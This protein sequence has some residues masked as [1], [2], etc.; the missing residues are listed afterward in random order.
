MS[1]RLRVRRR[2]RLIPLVLAAGLFL[3]FAVA[4]AGA[5]VYSGATTQ[6]RPI[7]LLAS[8]SGQLKHVRLSLVA[9]CRRGGVTFTQ[10]SV[11]TFR[12]VVRR[13]FLI[14]SAF[15]GRQGAFRYRT[16]IVLRGHRSST[17]AWAG[18]FMF[19]VLIWRHNRAYDRCAATGVRW[20]AR[21]PWARLMMTSDPGDYIGQG[22]SYSYVTPPDPILATRPT[23]HNEVG[24]QIGGWMLA[25]AAPGARRLTPGTYPGAQRA[26][27]KGSHPGLEVTGQ[28]RGCNLLTG[29]FTVTALDYTRTGEIKDL[30][31]SF[32]QHCEGEPAALRGTLSYHR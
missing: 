10:Q 6:H 31:V 19:T 20:E 27:F 29:S 21:T 7:D 26:S 30:V 23:T 4:P 16:R 8:P 18:S 11:F 3:S 22:R 32:E 13:H 12:E 9:R 17:H 1:P 14:R 15:R 2:I 5:Y 28:G 25:F 24:L